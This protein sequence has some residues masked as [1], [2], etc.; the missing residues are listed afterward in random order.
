SKFIKM[1]RNTFIKNWGSASYGLLLKEIYDAEIIGN[2]FEENTIGINTEGCTRINYTSNTFKGNG[3]AVKVAGAC[4]SNIFK[5]NM[6]L[7]GPRPER[8]VFVKKLE[9]KLPYYH[10][11][12]AIRPGLTGWAQVNYPYGENFEDSK[13]KLN[14]DLYYV[15]H[16]SWHLD[17]HIF[18]MTIREVFFGK[19]Q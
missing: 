6:D 13:E 15:K 10:L 5:G 19:G 1:E 16:L 2:L 3:W 4:Y 7:V 12:H 9:K 14:Y 11:R 18:V 8:E 17:L